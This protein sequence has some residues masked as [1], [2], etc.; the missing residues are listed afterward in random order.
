MS[1]SNSKKP[2]PAISPQH[3]EPTKKYATAVVATPQTSKP[4][5]AV[6]ETKKTYT[7]T[8]LEF[9]KL[10]GSKNKRLWASP[11]GND[12]K[13]LSDEMTPPD[14]SQKAA[15][16]Q[17][18][19]QTRLVESLTNKTQRR[20]SDPGSA[21]ESCALSTQRQRG[22]SVSTNTSRESGPTGSGTDRGR[23]EGPATK[24]NERVSTH[25]STKRQWAWRQRTALV[26][27]CSKRTD[28]ATDL[29]CFQRTI[30]TG[31]GRS[32]I[33][34]ATNDFTDQIERQSV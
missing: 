7:Q 32:R 16:S 20:A 13:R 3:R 22:E 18:D 11:L 26:R 12:A 6:S 19:P 21:P 4:Q 10:P 29:C 24:H 33:H 30:C 2:L 34:K 23:P 28:S 1:S 9:T 14:T 15:S 31:C 25:C 5:V 27:E 8:G 17:P